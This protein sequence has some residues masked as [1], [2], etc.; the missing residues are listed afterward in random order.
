MAIQSLSV[1]TETGEGK[2]Y[3]AEQYGFVIEKANSECISAEYK[4]T[5]LSGDVKAGT[6][7]ARKFAFGGLNPYGTARTAGAGDKAKAQT[8]KV[9]LDD[10]LE[11]IHE[12]EQADVMLLGVEGTVERLLAD[13]AV[14]IA[15]DNEEKFWL[16]ASLAGT[17]VTP[18]AGDTTI[19]KKIDKLIVALETTKGQFVKGVSR[20]D[21]RLVLSPTTYTQLQEHIDTLPGVNGTTYEVFH[22]VPVESSVDLPE[23]VDAIVLRV[24]SVAQPVIML[25]LDSGKIPLSN[26]YSFGFQIKR[27]TKATN[28]E[29][30]KTLGEPTISFKIGGTSYTARYG[31]T[32][33]EWVASD[34]NT[35]SFKIASDK[36]QTSA[37]KDVLDDGTAVAKTDVLVNG[38]EYTV[39]A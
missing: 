7:V 23:G 10:D 8:V 26:A 22:K 31:S 12:I 33:A 16:V 6:L 24:K 29:L 35:A 20:K 4:N 2:A 37:S 15:K 1:L 39:S 18:G 19:E 21:M 27:G 38:A 34:Y 14:T 9:D 25:P 17:K 28:P 3:L 36:L 5:D 13:D 11:I 32:A 30:I